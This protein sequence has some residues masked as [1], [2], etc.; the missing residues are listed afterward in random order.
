MLADCRGVCGVVFLPFGPFPLLNP[1]VHH[2]VAHGILQ[3]LSK[4]TWHKARLSH[5][6]R[7]RCHWLRRPPLVLDGL[8][9]HGSRGLGRGGGFHFRRFVGR[10]GAV[11]LLKVMDLFLN[12]QHICGPAGDDYGDPGTKAMRLWHQPPAA[13][14]AQRA[15]AAVGFLRPKHYLW[16][17]TR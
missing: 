8:G 16:W 9:H 3:G 1:D 2:H 10:L 17:P 14:R 5:C 12:V 13:R 4:I 7:S 15:V 11:Y 6:P